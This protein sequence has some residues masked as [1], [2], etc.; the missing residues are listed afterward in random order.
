[1]PAEPEPQREQG[2][3]AKRVTHDG[4][5]RCAERR[6]GP[7]QMA[8]GQP[9]PRKQGTEEHRP[10]QVADHRMTRHRDLLSRTRDCNSRPGPPRLGAGSRRRWFLVHAHH[11]GRPPRARPTPH[12]RGARVRYE[13]DRIGAVDRGKPW[14]SW[15][16]PSAATR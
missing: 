11:Y 2:P 12:R 1:M 8:E 3:P 6:H 16:T 14:T 9:F 13:A 7:A 5:E 10:H 15:T 4:P